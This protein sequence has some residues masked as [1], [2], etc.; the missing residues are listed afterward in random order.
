MSGGAPRILTASLDR[1]VSEPHWSPDGKSIFVVLEDDG[2]E[3]LVRVPV[4]IGVGGP[5][6]FQ[7]IV[8]GRRK[9]TAYDVSQN[10][11]VVVRAS[12]PDRPY[13]I[14]AAEDG[15][16]RCLTKQNDNFLAGIDL[17]RSEETKFKSKDGTEVHGFVI[18]PPNEK[19]GAKLKTLLRPHGGPQSQYACEFDFEKQLFAANDYLVV[20]PNPRG[21]TGRGTDYAMK[22]YADWGHRDVEDDLAAVDDV[23]RRGL[24]DPER[25]GVGGWSYGGMSTN[26]LIASTTRF[27]AATSGA[28][29]S[30]IIA[31]YGTDQYIRD[32]EYELGSPWA[33]PEVWARVSYPF[34]HADRIKTPTLFLG[35]E[36][37]FNVP[38]LNSEQIYQALKTLD[39]PTE[40][41]IYP[42]QFHGLKKPSYL[43]DRFQRYLD[44]Y[45]R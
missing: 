38:L 41:V 34:L 11:N 44:W 3:T 31:G 35:G 14:F 1:N 30:D 29:I 9:V 16:L 23:V 26:Y 25:L 37:D 2:A 6:P 10:G 22:I 24:A 39:V 21:S 36:S 27:K 32:Y 8:G 7:P 33:H 42:G 4:I 12:T 45:R 5:D 43:L 18:D 40:L 20:L 19:P 17:G 15:Q 13:E 28:S